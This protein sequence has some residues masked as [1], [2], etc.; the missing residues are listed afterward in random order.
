MWLPYR[1]ITLDNSQQ[2]K[3]IYVDFIW[4][5]PIK[6]WNHYKVTAKEIPIEH[7]WE[8]IKV[9]YDKTSIVDIEVLWT[10][11]H[12]QSIK[13]EIQRILK[14]KPHINTTLSSLHQ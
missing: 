13:Q 11:K 12:L 3:N 5:F 7:I 14:N 8:Q 6:E 2:T 4:A 9:I 1:H 10:T